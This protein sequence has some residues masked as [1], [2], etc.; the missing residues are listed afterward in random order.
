LEVV[1]RTQM[2]RHG[3]NPNRFEIREIEE[4]DIPGF[5]E[6]LDAVARERR[7]LALLEAPPLEK[8]REFVRASMERGDVRVV[9]VDGDQV[10]GWCDI[11]PYR[12]EGLDH[13]GELGMGVLKEYRGKGIGRSLLGEALRL[14]QDRGLEKVELDVFASSY[15]AI[16]LYEEEGFEIEGRKRQARKLHGVYDDIIVM[17][18]FLASR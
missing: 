7:F 4:A 14:A 5:R 12:F 16:S 1:N 2:I 11:R 3:L 6:C 17:G 13:A 8:V 10:V 15:A 18:L 9:A